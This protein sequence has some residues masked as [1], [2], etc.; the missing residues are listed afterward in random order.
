MKLWALPFFIVA[1]ASGCRAPQSTAPA[2]TPVAQAPP[3]QTVSSPVGTSW[4]AADIGGRA[5]AGQ[6]QSTLVFE[7]ETRVVGSTGCNRYFA[8]LQLSGTTLR[9]ANIGSTRMACVLP[10]AMEQETRFLAGLEAARAYGLDSNTNQLW[11]LGEDGSELARFTRM[12]GPGA[13][14]T[15]SEPAGNTAP[16]TLA[17]YFFQCANGPSLVAMH[18]ASPEVVDIVVFE[19]KQRLTRVAAASGAKYSTGGVTY[20]NKGREATL[21]INGGSYSCVEE[22]AGSIRED[23]RVRGAVFRGTGN[24]P[25]WVLEILADRIVFNEPFADRRAIVPRPTAT[26]ESVTEAHRLQGRIEQREC[27][28]SMSGDRFEAQVEVQLDGRTYRGC[29]YRVVGPR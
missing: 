21:D 7:S 27:L 15:P 22:R 16:G 18:T 1:L 9:L 5:V 2:T 29:G 14:T 19:G 23:A 24:E 10:A 8:G 4:L 26:F 28:D 12:G 13:G 17:A 11:L 6:V 3:A 25:S 20:W